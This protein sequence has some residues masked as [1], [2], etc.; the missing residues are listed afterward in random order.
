MRGARSRASREAGAVPRAVRARARGRRA[1]AAAARCRAATPSQWDDEVA[2]TCASRPSSRTS[3]RS[4]R[5]LKDI[6]GRAGAGAAG[7]L[8]DHRPHLARRATSPRTSPAAKYLMEQGVEPKDFN[9]YGA[10]R[11][12]HEVMVRGTFANIRLKNLLVPGVEGG[13]TVHLPTGEQMSHLRRVD[14]VPEGRHAAGGAGR[15]GV[16]H[17]Q[18]ARLGGQGH[19]AARACGR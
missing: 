8:G 16:R 12:N 4:R 14:E 7:R 3:R 11:G 15:R 17:R 18:L 2:P 1:V 9:S 13:V 6:D 5:P 10:R 19:A